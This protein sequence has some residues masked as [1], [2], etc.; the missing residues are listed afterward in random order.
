MCKTRFSTFFSLFLCMGLL[1]TS[2]LQAQTAL[3][4]IIHNSPSNAS[5]EGVDIY[6]NGVLAANNLAFREA[7]PFTPVPANVP[8]SVGVAPGNSTSAL[9]ILRDT[10]LTLEADKNYIGI[11]YGIFGDPDFPLNLAVFEQGRLIAASGSGADVLLFHGS[12]G[13]PGFDVLSGGEVVFNDVYY[14]EFSQDYVNFPAEIV[15]FQLTPNDDNSNVVQSYTA[16]L[17]TGNGLAGVVFASGIL[18]GTPALEAW[19]AL[20]DG[21]TFPLPP[22]LEGET[23]YVQLINNSPSQPTS[24]VDIYVDGVLAANNFA[25]RT[26]TPYT[27]VPAGV[28]VRVSV[29]PPNSTSVDDAVFDTIITLVPNTYYIGIAHGIFGDATRPASFSIFDRGRAEADEEDEVDILFFHGGTDAPGG[30]DVLSEGSILFDDVFYGTFSDD[31]VSIPAG[32][33]SIDITSAAGNTDLGTWEG[34][35]G[36][37]RGRTAVIF[38]TGLLDGQPAFEPWV[39]LS[40][41]GTFPLTRPQATDSAYVQLIHDSYSRPESTVDIYVNGT[42]AVNNMAYRTAT[43]FTPVPAGVPIQIG[44]APANS[45]SADDI[46]FDTIVTLTT[47]TNY[48]GV[49]HGIFG[50]PNYPAELSVFDMGRLEASADGNVDLLF[51]QGSPGTPTGLDVISGSNTLFNDVFYGTFSDDYISIPAGPLTLNFTGSTGSPEVGS[52]ETSFGFWR[53]KTA[54]IFATGYLGGQEPAFEPW[55]A[56]SNGGTYPLESGDGGGGNGG[57]NG[58]PDFNLINVFPNPANTFTR[59]RLNMEESAPV[60]LT[61]TPLPSGSVVLQQNLGILNPGFFETT[62]DLTGVPNGTYSLRVQSPDTTQ[63]ITLVILH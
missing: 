41:G 13:A 56:L 53:G 19:V 55:V 58:I 8:L 9:D 60:T 21:T 59:I 11:A 38:I 5:E 7:T 1:A 25:Y 10:V 35:L 61:L 2:F 18:E 43:P 57:G 32:L 63:F 14:G 28:P 15:S 46:L 52:Y 49:A 54:V 22:S 16:D 51:F 47:G 33:L 26:A 24:T 45:T 44:V 37:W 23:A 40:N 31:Y 12:P 29:A 20:P 30:L 42:L 3:V 6:V 34:N 50:D 62:L 4:Q 48:I 39:A 17:L 36:F 27:A